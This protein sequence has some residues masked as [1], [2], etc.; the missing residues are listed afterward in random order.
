MISMKGICS[1]YFLSDQNEMSNTFFVGSTDNTLFINIQ[2]H[3][4][5]V[6]AEENSLIEDFDFENE[7]E[8]E[9][10][11]L[12]SIELLPYYFNFNTTQGYFLNV[13]STYSFTS[14]K[15]HFLDIFS[16]PPNC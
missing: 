6:P 1:H 13:Y 4:L 10:D 2:N 15:I 16:P 3:T 7:V 9:L 5:P 14:I 8:V 12:P 11:V